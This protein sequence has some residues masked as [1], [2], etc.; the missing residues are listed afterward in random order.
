MLL[1]ILALF[2]LDLPT[3]VISPYKLQCNLIV[4]LLEKRFP[5]TYKQVEVCTVDSFQGGEKDV[6][7]LSLVRSNRNDPVQVGFL[8]DKRRLNVSVTRAKYHLAVVCNRQMLATSN[9]KHLASFMRYLTFNAAE[10]LPQRRKRNSADEDVWWRNEPCPVSLKV[11]TPAEASVRPLDD[12]LLITGSVDSGNSTKSPTGS[13]DSLPV[14]GF[15]ESD[16][17][18]N[19]DTE[20]SDYSD[21]LSLCSSAY[22][23]ETEEI[24]YESAL[25]SYYSR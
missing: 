14:S 25:D 19:E 5:K 15:N 17:P 20:S 9:C 12:L 7:I 1:A 4:Q 11:T 18:D 24:F 23:S 2:S 6:I 16:N 21:I 10:S 8:R 22:E 3:G 13:V